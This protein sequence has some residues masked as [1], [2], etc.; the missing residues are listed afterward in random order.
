MVKPRRRSTSEAVRRLGGQQFAQERLNPHRP[1]RR[2]IPTGSARLPAGGLAT[3]GGAQ[4]I[5]V[6]FVEPGAAQPEFFGGVRRGKFFPA[7]GGQH[8]TD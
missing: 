3:G 6:E 5:G 7:K 4:V 8:L 2:M 1:V